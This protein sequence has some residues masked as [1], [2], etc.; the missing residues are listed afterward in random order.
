VPAP[1]RALGI[2]PRE[3]DQAQRRTRTVIVA[4][5]TLLVICAAVSVLGAFAWRRSV[6]RTVAQSFTSD[7]SNLG[8]SLATALRRDMDFMATLRGAVAADPEMDGA[9]YAR[10][11]SSI[12][13][14]QR[15][16]GG[17]GYAYFQRVR[18]ADL[19]AF[20][21]RVLADPPQGFLISRP[22]TVTPPGDRLYYCLARLSQSSGASALLPVG[23]DACGNTGAPG[24][25]SSSLAAL[26]EAADT[27]QFSVAT[28]DAAQGIFGVTAPVYRTGFTPS[29]PA[30]RQAEFLGWMSGSFNAQQ[31]IADAAPLPTGVGA[32]ITHVGRHNATDVIARAGAAPTGEDLTYTLPVTADG[33]WTVQINGRPTVGGL[34][35]TTQGVFVL[36]GGLLVAGLSFAFMQFMGRSRGQALRLVATRTDQLR[37]QALHDALTGLPNRALILDRVEQ[38]MARARRNDGQMAVMF[39]DLDGFKGIND[40]FGHSAGDRVL[41]A[42]AARLSGVLRE[43]DTVGRLGG[44]EFVILIDGVSMDAGPELVAER[45]RDVLAQ[46][47]LLG[48]DDLRLT[49]RASIGIAAGVRST[50]GELLRDADVALYEAKNAGKDRFVVFAPEMQTA[51]QDRLE[52][53]MDLRDAVGTDQLFLVYQPTFDLREVTVTGVEALIR[54]NHPTRGLVGPDQFIPLAEETGLIVPIGRWVLAEACRQAAEWRQRGHELSISVNVSARQLE[55]DQDFLADVRATLEATAMDPRLLILEITESMLMRDASASAER[56]H[57]LKALGLRIAIDDFGTGYS[58]LAYLQQF[59]VDSLKID[60]SFI[61]GVASS[62]ES[63]ALIHTLVQLGKA[64]GIETLAEGIE[65]QAQLLNLQ[66]EQCDSGQGYLFARPLPPAELEAL[67]A[68]MPSA[69]SLAIPAPAGGN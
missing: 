29:T 25:P 6:Q 10:L 15:Y 28:L 67:L 36:V 23:F 66:R 60:R 69:R 26:V 5:W 38:A 32:Q 8:A 68:T 33:T 50:A 37:Y 14:A 61:S 30:A 9:S 20:A 18:A 51:V 49:A 44:D 24:I 31:L 45:I 17:L 48:E 57:A 2:Q 65:E 21:S 11:M 42:V 64:L 19:P 1:P 55:S 46:P 40:T 39:L 13:P 59:P 53:E 47:F 34:S 4:S 63:T 52:L 62:P 3:P 27:G 41:Q 43:S 58:S 22:Y 7:A 35:A 16:P 56:L 12:S 54:W